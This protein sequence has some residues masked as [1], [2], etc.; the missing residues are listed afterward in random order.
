MRAGNLRDRVTLQKSVNVKDDVGAVKKE[1]Q[2]DKSFWANVIPL[3]GS[4]TDTDNE[5][6]NEQYFKVRYRP[7]SDV[8]KQDRFKW[9]GYLLEIV[10]IPVD[11]SGRRSEHL[12]ECR[13]IL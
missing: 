2:D 3:R 7:R 4:E 6:T 8:Q 1:W 10:T 13:V 5:R 12:V 11:P 9:N